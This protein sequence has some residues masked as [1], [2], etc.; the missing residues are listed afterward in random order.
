MEPATLKSP[1]PDLIKQLQA[2]REEE[3]SLRLR[4][5]VSLWS[6]WKTVTS[7]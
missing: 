4:C 5:G 7:S 3:I 2:G 1:A 6:E